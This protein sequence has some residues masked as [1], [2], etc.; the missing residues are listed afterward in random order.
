MI[1]NILVLT[2]CFTIISVNYA[3]KKQKYILGN[4]YLLVLITSVYHHSTISY[5]EDQKY[6]SGKIDKYSIYFVA[7]YNI[8]IL[9]K[10][11]NYYLIFV[12]VLVFWLFLCLLKPVKEYS[13]FEYLLHAF[14]LHFLGNV[15][16][17]YIIT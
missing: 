8:Y 7:L 3:F 4:L 17:C 10:L 12:Y 1:N 2:S 14:M 13:G 6:I 9:I 16:N 11:K 15:M 5:T